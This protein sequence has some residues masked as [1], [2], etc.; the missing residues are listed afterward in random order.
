MYKEREWFRQSRRLSSIPLLLQGSSAYLSRK[1]KPL[2]NA[3][4]RMGTQPSEQRRA[5]RGMISSSSLTLEPT[6]NSSDQG[7]LSYFCNKSMSKEDK[8]AYY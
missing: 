6:D 5:A 8:L 4:L 2:Q 7:F 1:T 3:K